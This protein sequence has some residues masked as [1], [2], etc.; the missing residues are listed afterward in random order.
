MSK[1]TPESKAKTSDRDQERGP[2][3]ET[4]KEKESRQRAT[5]PRCTRITRV[6]RRLHK[7]A[8]DV[9]ERFN[10][11]TAIRRLVLAADSSPFCMASPAHS[12]YVSHP[13]LMLIYSVSA[14]NHPITLAAAHSCH[15]FST[16]VALS[17]SASTATPS[18]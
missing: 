7:I 10:L 14:Q 4:D 8:D 5:S 12:L 9:I 2:E 13:S 1:E 15:I 16:L 11:A 6:T 17:E 18:F 3:G